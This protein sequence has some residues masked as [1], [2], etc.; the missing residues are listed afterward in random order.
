MSGC[1]CS[2]GWAEQGDGPYL[3]KCISKCFQVTEGEEKEE[4]V[5]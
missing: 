5:F 3:K 4:I 1:R 2:C